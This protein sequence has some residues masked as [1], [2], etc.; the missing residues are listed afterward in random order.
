MLEPGFEILSNL[1]MKQIQVTCLHDDLICLG[2]HNKI[3]QA[4]WL[5]QQKV[6]SHS[7]EGGKPNIKMPANLVPGESPLSALQVEDTSVSLGPHRAERTLWGLI[8]FFKATS[9]IG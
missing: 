6:I 2:C 3:P 7:F 4:R 8:L 5:K 9:P 1:P